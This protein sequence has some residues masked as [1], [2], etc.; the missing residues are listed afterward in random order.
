MGSLGK[1]LTDSLLTPKRAKG[2][3]VHE[4]PRR[5]AGIPSEWIDKL[6]SL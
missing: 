3:L 5:Q 2:F 1:D 6:K 4:E